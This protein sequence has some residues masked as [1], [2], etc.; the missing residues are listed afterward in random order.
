[1]DDI[2]ILYENEYLGT[3]T[4]LEKTLLKTL[5]KSENR[6]YH[7]IQIFLGSN[8][9]AK[10]RKVEEKDIKD[11]NKFLKK[12]NINVFTHL[13]YVYN[14]AGSVKE[15]CYCWE[16]NTTINDYTTTCL[17][18]INYEL[19]VLDKLNCNHKGCVLH[20]GSVGKLD[21]QKGLLKVAESINKLELNKLTNGS[22]LI[23]ETM[24]GA[25]GVLGT[26]FKELKIVYDN[27]IEKDK[28]GI[29]I[30]TCHI[31]AEG[32]YELSKIEMINAMFKDFEDI[33]G[34][35]KLSLIHLNDSKCECKSKKD[36][37]EKIGF[38]CI[39]KEK[40]VAY[41][42]LKKIND[43]KIP[44]VCETVEEDYDNIQILYQICKK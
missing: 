25:G 10:R 30:D 2:I 12:C 15:K 11:C 24:V 18:S 7:N 9:T 16:D 1:M 8:L 36:R 14:L 33:F 21:K 28:I 34:M 20:I 32:N 39:F 43:L 22:K 4:G 19:Q 5:E 17:E 3:H 29:C 13:P 31:F 42:M 35:D 44:S 37:H 6:G 23:L 26:S 27:I 41:Y 38:G 40:E